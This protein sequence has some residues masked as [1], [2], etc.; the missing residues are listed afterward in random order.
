MTRQRVLIVVTLIGLLMISCVFFDRISSTDSP[1]TDPVAEEPAVDEEPAEQPP[2]EEPP[3][4]I[5]E[6]P[7]SPLSYDGPWWIFS[8]EEGLY[9]LNP[10]GSGLTQFYFGPT[11]PPYAQ[12]FEASPGGGT[13]AYIMGDS[14][15]ATLHIFD[16]SSY[17]HISEKELLTF[18]SDPGMDAMRAVVEQPSFAFSPDGSTLAFMGAI[19][20]PTSDLYVF[21]LDTYQTSRLTDGISQGYQPVWSPDGKYIVHTGVSSFGT[22]AGAAMSGVWAANASDSDDVKSLYDPSGSGGETIIGWTDDETFLVYSWDAVCGSGNLRTFN[23]EGKESEIIWADSFRAIDYD[24]ANEVVVLSSN[25]GMCAPDGGAGTY[26][27]PTDGKSPL[28]V[29]DETPSQLAWSADANL[30][31]ASG[32]FNAW[33]IAIDSNGQFIDL[34]MPEGAKGDPAVAP[35]SR[36]LAWH[37]DAL[38]VGALL[39]AIENPP[40]QIFNEPV[41]NA[42]WTPDGQAIIFFADS[43]LYIAQRPDYTP[44]LIATGLNNRDGYSGWVMPY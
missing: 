38:W 31:L 8:T 17:T 12:H 23:F 11:N 35:G 36:D 42:T 29:L 20:G 7:D 18:E 28:R 4:E 2:V 37:G 14:Y 33:F 39:G 13:L 34:D 24:P 26:L 1:V 9:A 15:N 5:L 25:D 6:I 40:Q 27:V 22:G 44:L 30:F 19:E 21:S 10:D 41:Y 3:A 43:G 32:D 16:F